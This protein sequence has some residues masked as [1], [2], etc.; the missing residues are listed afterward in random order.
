M[1]IPNYSTQELMAARQLKGIPPAQM[2]GKVMDLLGKDPSMSLSRLLALKQESD[3]IDQQQQVQQ[4]MLMAQQGGQQMP[5]MPQMPP[6]RMPQQGMPPQGMPQGAPQQA[7]T[8]AQELE[9]KV[10]AS[11]AEPMRQGGIAGLPIDNFQPGN[12]ANGGI[13]AFDAGG[14]TPFEDDPSVDPRSVPSQPTDIDTSLYSNVRGIGAKSKPSAKTLKDFIADFSAQTAPYRGQTEESQARAEEIRQAKTDLIKQN[15]QDKYAN[16]LLAGLGIAGGTSPYFAA[17]LSNAAPA[18]KNY[19]QNQRESKKQN[20]EYSKELAAI[21]QAQRAEGLED[22][23]GGAALM[24]QQL[25]RDIQKAQ[26]DK[27]SAIIEYANRYFD[28]AVSKGDTRPEGQIRQEAMEKY[29]TLTALPRIEAQKTIAAMTSGPASTNA[30]TNIRDAANDFAIALAGKVNDFMKTREYT[31]LPDGNRNN[32][33]DKEK[34]K[35]GMKTKQQAVEDFK[36]SVRT[37]AALHSQIG[38]PGETVKNLPTTKP[39]AG[40]GTQTGQKTP[41]KKITP[42]TGFYSF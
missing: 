24:S 6:Q 42:P 26:A 21:A 39:A 14:V 13:I 11:A 18:V 1:T 10:A 37:E 28:N 22:V 3:R 4:A 19:M 41:A 7:P 40:A 5:Q 29:T 38:Q 30:A 32:E 15:E 31:R 9:Q 20:L 12:Y 34:I 16:I 33:N 23:K 8:V 36:N 27:P 17:N 25:T 2:S 35:N